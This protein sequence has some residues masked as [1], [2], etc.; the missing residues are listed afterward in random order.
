MA[1]P[2]Q[3]SAL[4][5]TLAVEASPSMGLRANITFHNASQ[6]SMS[7]WNRFV[8]TDAI[9]GGNWFRITTPDGKRLPYVGQ[10]AKWPAPTP[11]D[12]VVLG[13]GDS[14]TVMMFIVHEYALPPATPV[15]IRFEA[16]NPSV[17]GQRLMP[18]VSNEVQVRTP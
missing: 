11:R 4:N 3:E 1:R 10:L 12:F 17:G 9:L 16:F 5:V 7:L 8:P 2:P 14:R 15:T 18:L 13:P 6:G